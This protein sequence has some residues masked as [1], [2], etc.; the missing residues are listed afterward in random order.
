MRFFILVIMA[1]AASSAMSSPLTVFVA[2]KNTPAYDT[3]RSLEDDT[4]I[5]AERRI[6]RAFQRVAEHLANCGTCT[7]R[8][9]IAGGSYTGKADVGLWSFPDI[10]APDARLEILGG[11][12]DAF[13]MRDP[14]ATPTLLVSSETRSGPVLKF[15]GRKHA[16]GALVISGLAFDVSPSNSYDADSRSLLKGSSSTWPLLSLGYLSTSSLTITDNIF[17]NAAEGVGGPQIRIL[18]PD[19]RIDIANNI[20]FNSV[21]PWVV[22][23]GVSEKMPAEIRIHGN[24]FVLNWPYNPDTTTSNPGALEIGNNYATRN[25]VIE[26]NLFA[27]NMG[28]AIFPQWDDD[29]GPPITI[30]DNLFWQN[31]LMFGP[32]DYGDGGAVVGKFAGS[33]VHGVFSAEDVEDDFDW[34]TEDNVSF[35]PGLATAPPD[36][37]AVQYGSDY[38]G[39]DGARTAGET[40]V[41]DTQVEEDLDDLARQLAALTGTPPTDET[42]EAAAPIEIVGP[43][44]DVR[45]YAPELPFAEVGLPFPS[46]PDAAAYGASP[47][48][49]WQPGDAS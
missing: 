21:T 24:S 12:D 13:Q 22:P 7:A 42:G 18:T 25:L 47:D 1:L 4:T 41:V 20:F 6:H 34:E 38:R 37:K 27:F 11:W 16:I 46:N 14:F 28:G 19:T 33:A 43:D 29:R 9:N 32:N 39:A 31:G 5:F 44:N 36:L 8:I 15:E 3:A 48:R 40:P 26:R 10:Q 23:G 35:D 2:P 17:M 30:R 49:I 45:N